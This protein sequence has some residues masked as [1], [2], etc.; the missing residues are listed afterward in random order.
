MKSW[1]LTFALIPFLAWILI[2]PMKDKVMPEL[3]RGGTEQILAQWRDAM[4]AFKAEE[5][6]FPQMIEGFTKDESRF[7]VLTGQNK[8]QKEYLDRHSIKMIV[9]SKPVDAWETQLVFD[10][11]N[12]GDQTH[13]ISAG[14]DLTIGTEDDIDSLKVTQRNLPVPVELLDDKTRRKLEFNKATAAKQAKKGE[15]AEG[16]DKDQPAEPPTK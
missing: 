3:L 14:P 13:I 16:G 15:K 1:L 2:H 8:A 7:T 5:G 9:G 10:P 4:V 12:T 11:Q 6:E